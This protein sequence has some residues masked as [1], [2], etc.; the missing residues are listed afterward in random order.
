MPTRKGA[1]MNGRHYGAASEP[2]PAGCFSLA[3]NVTPTAISLCLF[4]VKLMRYNTTEIKDDAEQMEAPISTVPGHI[5][6][7]Q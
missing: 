3:P 6:D 5:A 7:L 1:I 4:R 2:G